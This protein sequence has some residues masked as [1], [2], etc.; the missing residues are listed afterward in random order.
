M[1]VPMANGWVNFSPLH[2][3]ANITVFYINRQGV[4]IGMITAHIATL[5]VI[6]GSYSMEKP[7]DISLSTSI[8]VS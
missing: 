3:K 2:F 1:L 7:A 5:I 4:S 6:C 8:E